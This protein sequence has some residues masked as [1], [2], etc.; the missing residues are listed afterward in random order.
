MKRFISLII[1][2]CFG[3]MMAQDAAGTYKLTGTNVRYTSLLRQTSTVS[4]T[5]AY[6]LGVTIPLAT[7]PINAPAGQLI[8]GPF[9]EDNLELSGAFLNVTFN[10]D[11][12]GT[13]NEGSYY[14]TL[15]L[16]EETC[17][18]TGAALPITDELVYTSNLTPANYVQTTTLLGIPSLSPFSGGFI[19]GISLSQ[20]SELDFFTFGQSAG[21][22]GACG[23]GFYADGSPCDASYPGN[24]C[25]IYEACMSAGYVSKGHDIETV[26][27]NG[28]RDMYVEWHAIDGPLS[29][30]GFGDDETDPCEDDLCVANADQDQCLEADGSVSPACTAE[31]ESFDRILGVPGLP[32]TIMNPDCGYG[33]FIVGGSD[34]VGPALAGGVQAACQS[35]M[36]GDA[37]GNGY[38]DVVDGCF[39]LSGAGYDPAT[40]A[41]MAFVGACTQLGFDEATCTELAYL[42]QMSVESTY[43]CYDYVSHEVDY[44]VTSEE[45]CVGATQMWTPMAW[46][47]Y[48]LFG[49]TQQSEALCGAAAAAWLGDCVLGD[50]LSATFNV[51]NEDLAPWGGFLTWNSVMYSQCAAAG[52]GDACNAYLVPDAGSAF[53]PTCLAD[54]DSSDCSGRLLM[55]MDPTCVPELQVREVYIDFDQIDDS[56]GTGDISLDGIVNI[57]DVVALVQLILGGG[58][59]TADDLCGGDINADGVLSILD[60]VAIIQTILGGRTDDASMIEIFNNNNIVTIEADGYVGA[61]QMTLAHGNDFSINLTNDAYVAQSHTDGNQTKLMVVNPGS[62]LFTAQGEFEI[63]E[64]IAANGNDYIDVINPEAISLSDAYPNPFNPTTSFELQVGNA[65]HVTM[66]VYNLMG[67]VV[68]TLVNN[69]MDAGNY[70]ITWDAANFSSGMYIVKAETVN[71]I[72]SQ[73]VMLVK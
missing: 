34:L 6:G 8:N 17:I 70:N 33:D 55:N 28:V 9:N 47:C 43:I 38:P 40:A 56:C 12:T 39:G 44:T 4:A 72:A 21:A 57:L 19:G 69:T 36:S 5:D 51:L 22:L 62:E 58:E 41:T 35:G 32:S 60:V 7:F 27:G 67:Q 66:N 16:D 53:D 54:G 2:G 14:P 49:L 24:D 11:G 3:L 59:P 45:D 73:K 61:V 18:T 1:V 42:A 20:S 65:G 63:V 46:D 10:E 48:G 30:S 31:L 26:E 68:S 25:A 37:D 71:G 15:D 29:Q 50:G 64:V 23:A 52:G 13:V